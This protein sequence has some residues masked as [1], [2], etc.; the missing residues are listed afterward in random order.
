[1]PRILQIKRIKLSLRLTKSNFHLTGLQHLVR[2][3][4][5]HPQSQTSVYNIFTQPQSKTY[6]SL[7][8]FFISYGVVVERTCHPRN[9]R[10]KT[11]TILCTDHLLQNNSHLL[12]V[13][14]IAG[15]LHIRLAVS[16]EN[17]SIHPFYGIA[18]HTEHLIFII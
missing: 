6:S 7:F 17:R 1:M 2:M 9:R 13:Y 18:Q 4:R 5:T 3:I 8:G 12:L 15:C 14:H 10:I 16:E 11:V